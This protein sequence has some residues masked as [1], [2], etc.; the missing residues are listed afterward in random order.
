MERV[1]SPAMAGSAMA[2]SMTMVTVMAKGHGQ[3]CQ[4]Q[5]GAR[6]QNLTAA[7]RCQP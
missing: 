7:L 6:N 2:E 1:L 4:G 5:N 3:G